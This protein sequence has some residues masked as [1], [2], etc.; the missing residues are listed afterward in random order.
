MRR[1]GM[2]ATA[3][4][5]MLA[6]SAAQAGQASKPADVDAARDAQV[7]AAFNAIKA[8]DPQSAL[9]RAQVVIDLY[10]K[11]FAQ[12]KRRIYCSMNPTETLMYLAMAAKDKVDAI[13][14]SKVYCSA[15]FMKEYALFDLGRVPEARAALEEAIRLAPMHAHFYTELGQ[16]HRLEKDWPKMLEACKQAEQ[17]VGFAGQSDV[18]DEKGRAMRCQGYALVELGKLEEAQTM[19]QRCVALNPNDQTAKEELEY[20]RKQRAKQN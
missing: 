13:A 20:I 8:K 10:A 2:V 15:L 19:Y 12:E 9:S 3:L 7:D 1:F 14:V 18:A 16:I 11:D 5:M 17:F 6:G 4:A